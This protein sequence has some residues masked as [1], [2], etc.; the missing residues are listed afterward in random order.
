MFDPNKIDNK[1]NNKLEEENKITYEEAVKMRKEVFKKDPDAY[2]EFL[3]LGKKLAEK[4]ENHNEYEMYHVLTFSSPPEGYQ[5]TE[6]DF[7]GDDS[8]VKFLKEKLA[9]INRKK[10]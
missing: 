1:Q 7:S 6:Y 4:Y 2:D 5:F 10:D 8:V 9:R 3:D